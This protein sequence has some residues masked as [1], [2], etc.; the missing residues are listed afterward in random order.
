MKFN[1][2][3]FTYTSVGTTDYRRGENIRPAN[4]GIF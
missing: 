1:K 3:K 2:I 4:T